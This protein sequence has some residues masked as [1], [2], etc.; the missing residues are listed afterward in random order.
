MSIPN[1][2]RILVGIMVLGQGLGQEEN[3]PATAESA[4]RKIGPHDILSIV[5]VGESNL[6][7]EYQVSAD[8]KIQFP[9]L[10]M[11]DA[12]GRTPRE[13]DLELERL[14][15]IDYFVKPEVLVA[16]KQY[17]QDYVLVT[18]Q[19][20]R[21]GPIPLDPSQRLS[22]LDAIVRAGGASRMAKDQVEFIRDGKVQK[23]SIDKLKRETDPA[24]KIW[25][26]AGDIL[27]VPEAIF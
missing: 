9:Y 21:Q 24:K 26:Q 22:I 27:N 10:D 19:V 2:I 3:L 20:G 15:S 16:V 1:L 4:D 17:H 6:P 11:V 23:L 13:L 14:L 7:S 5:I 25:L 18:G 12:Q 8:G